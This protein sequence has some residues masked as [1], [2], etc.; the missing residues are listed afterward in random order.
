MTAI[1][2]AAIVTVHD[3]IPVAAQSFYRLFRR[4]SPELFSLNQRR[5]VG[6]K[7]P[8][9]I[10]RIN[11]AAPSPSGSRGNILQEQN[12]RNR[13]KQRRDRFLPP[14]MQLLFHPVPPFPAGTHTCSLSPARLCFISVSDNS[15]SSTLF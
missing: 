12:N 5:R 7:I 6:V 4:I 1:K 8:L 14:A 15:A 10:I 13:Q 3:L 9:F 2:S 11:V